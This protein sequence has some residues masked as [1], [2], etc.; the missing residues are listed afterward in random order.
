MFECG[1]C[2]V[3]LQLGEEVDVV[4]FEQGVVYVVCQKCFDAVNEL[5]AQS[6]VVG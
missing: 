4:D 3:E 5:D 6:V 2:R 1:S